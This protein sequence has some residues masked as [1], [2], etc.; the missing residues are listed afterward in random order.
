MSYENKQ[1][2]AGTTPYYTE[3][4]NALIELCHSGRIVISQHD[5]A[6]Q[7]GRKVT[8][9]LRRALNMAIGRGALV[10]EDQKTVAGGVMAC[11]RFTAEFRQHVRSLKSEG[12]S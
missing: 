5:L 6:A 7:A 4:E 9:P 12:N 10:R 11:Y 2:R 8:A 3:I 1:Y